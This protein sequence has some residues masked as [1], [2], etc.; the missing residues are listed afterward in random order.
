MRNIFI[1]NLMLTF[2]LIKSDI[3]RKSLMVF[4][5]GLNF[6][7]CNH[8]MTRSRLDLIPINNNQVKN[9]ALSEMNRGYRKRWIVLAVGNV[10]RPLSWTNLYAAGDLEKSSTAHWITL[11]GYRRAFLWDD[12]LLDWVEENICCHLSWLT[13]SWNFSLFITKADLKAAIPPPC[14]ILS[15]Q[16]PILHC[17]TSQLA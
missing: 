17:G 16:F 11:V 2:H 15:P 5:H 12:L 8:I 10:K 1:Q 6:L 4:H 13:D 7:D 9:F 3:C 14:H